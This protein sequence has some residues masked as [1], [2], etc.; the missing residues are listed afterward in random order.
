MLTFPNSYASALSSPFK[1]NWL[2]RLYK[3]DGTYIGISFANVTMGDSI[4]Y[5]GAILNKPS[6]RESVDFTSGRSQNGNIT[7]EV[8]NFNISSSTL[9]K[10]LY[11]GNYLNQAVK[12]YSNM[13][14][15]TDFANTTQVFEGRLNSI[16]ATETEKLKLQ[17]V[18]K[19]PWDDIELPNEVSDNGVYV[20]VIYGNYTSN[21]YQASTNS[22]LAPIPYLTSNS[23]YLWFASHD[24][25]NNVSTHYYD[26]SA[27][28]FPVVSR[29][30]SATS[31]L[32][33]IN[34]V[35][36]LDTINRVY[37]IYPN[38][39]TTDAGDFSNPTNAIDT[40]TTTFATST[41][42]I[43]DGTANDEIDINLPQISGKIIEFK[44]YIKYDLSY[45]DN[46]QSPSHFVKLLIDADYSNTITTTTIFSDTDVAQTTENVSSSGNADINNSGSSHQQISLESL[47]TNNDNKLPDKLSIRHSASQ[48]N[49]S[50][51][52]ELSSTAKIYDVWFSLVAKTDTANEP[53]SAGQEKAQLEK[54]YVAHTGFS[55]SWSS[56]SASKPH[57]IHRDILYRFLGITATPNNY[58]T[59]ENQKNGSMRFFTEINKNEPVKKLLD[60]IAYEGG[61]VFRFRADGTPVYHFIEN[62]PSITSGLTLS[63]NDIMN[64]SISHT[65]LSDVITKWN[66]RFDKNPAMNEYLQNA[67]HTSSARTNFYVNSSKENTKEIKLKNLVDNVAHTGGNKNASFLDYYN[68]ILGNV[69]QIV[70]F[71]LMNPTKSYV[72]VGD[73]I[74]FDNSNMKIEAL[75]GAWTN[76]KFIVTATTRTIGG[77]VSVEA[78]E[79]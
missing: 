41:H 70:T 27:K 47:V 76:L 17:I 60:Q 38:L 36:V 59:L 31:T 52:E 49:N 13:N 26:K 77:E 57:E 56:G 40:D 67:S 53:N 2:V 58:N 28:L 21:T 55:K 14:A 11:S 73:I 65:P 4:S 50:S 48:T 16:D 29:G 9:L 23:I 32:E 6:I 69:K 25:T 30:S 10:T 43:N 35:P 3:S 37:R 68:S 1:E 34:A 63:H 72:E 18:V 66:I 42:N 19:R 64:L 5:T 22:K 44:M 78:R 45:I 20:P 12:I 24:S 75:S 8:A 7:L 62:S 54:I 71:S 33:G 15:N 39:D 46:E 79:I 61:F 51:N 74:N